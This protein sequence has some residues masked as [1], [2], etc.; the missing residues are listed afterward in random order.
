[1]RQLFSDVRADICISQ[2]VIR[3]ILAVV[4]SDDAQCD[5]PSVSSHCPGSLSVMTPLRPSTYLPPHRP[6]SAWRATRLC[7][8]YT[9]SACTSTRACTGADAGDGKVVE[10]QQPHHS[11]CLILPFGVLLR[12]GAMT[13]R[14]GGPYASRLMMARV[15]TRLGRTVIL[16]DRSDAGSG[17]ISSAML[18][19]AVVLL[20]LHA[21]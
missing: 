14:C 19:D 6:K 10:G 13:L 21:I 9:P 18:D 20:L 7:R 1:M 5:K 8:Q 2:K 12:A 3:L 17:A 4:C 11:R 16:Q 15:S